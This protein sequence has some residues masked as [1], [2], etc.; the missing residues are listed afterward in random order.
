M[1]KIVGGKGFEAIA[2][3]NAS[4][5]SVFLDSSDNLIKNKDSS[6][7]ILLFGNIPGE[8]KTFNLSVFTPNTDYNGTYGS[9]TDR[10]LTKI[11]T[12][13]TG[14]DLIDSGIQEGSPLYLTFEYRTSTTSAEYGEI[15][16]AINSSTS[17]GIFRCGSNLVTGGISY[18]DTLTFT[19][20]RMVTLKNWDSTTTFDIYERSGNEYDEVAHFRYLNI[21]GFPSSRFQDNFH[22]ANNSTISDADS[23]FNGV[24]ISNPSFAPEQKDSDS[25]GI[26]IK[27]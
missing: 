1:T 12:P 27:K 17:D 2:S 10:S 24:T 26:F 18:G 4:N 19:A 23:D 8:I 21:Y 22:F 3:S 25:I 13:F 5:N 9:Y 15:S 14:Q 20:A 11:A 16:M 6:G 7:N